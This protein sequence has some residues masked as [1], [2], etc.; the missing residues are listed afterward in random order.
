MNFKDD[1]MAEEPVSVLNDRTNC[2]NDGIT[3]ESV[4]SR[5][6][7]RVFGRAKAKAKM[8]RDNRKSTITW[9]KEI[10][11]GLLDTRTNNSSKNLLPQNGKSFFG[12]K[13]DNIKTQDET[14]VNI[15]VLDG[16]GGRGK[17]FVQTWSGVQQLIQKCFI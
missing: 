8:Q 12:I 3:Q 6:K 14:K 4:F 11:S 5:G 13:D 7:E 16:G 2:N 17:Y 10:N 9:L 15:L 1:G